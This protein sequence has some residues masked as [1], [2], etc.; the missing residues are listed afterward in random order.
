[1]TNMSHTCPANWYERYLSGLRLCGRESGNPAARSCSPV[2]AFSTGGV[3][4]S[5]VCGQARGYQYADVLGFAPSSFNPQ[6]DS[7]YADGLSLT[8][9]T[10]GLRV[11]IWTFVNGRSD[12]GGGPDACPC[13]TNSSGTA[14]PSIVGSKYFCESGVY[15]GSN[16]GAV[17]FLDDP[18][19]DGA[20]VLQKRMHAVNL[21]PH[22][23]SP[24]G[25][26]QLQRTILKDAY[27]MRH[28]MSLVAHSSLFLNFS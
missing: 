21:I 28:Q 9:G 13:N 5:Q 8:H 17:L 24:L 23:I 4:Y 12:V 27:V 2:A 19:W 1:M 3:P 14:P 15:D 18:L 20:G 11:H 26:L 25:F 7:Y 22:P 10:D 6:I 16:I